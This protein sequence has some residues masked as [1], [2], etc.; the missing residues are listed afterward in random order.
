MALDHASTDEQLSDL[1]CIQGGALPQV[2]RDNP[3]AQ[4]GGN[5]RILS[6]PSTTT[7]PGNFARRSLASWAVIF[8]S[9]SM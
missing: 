4:A 2:V 5:E 8:F 7:M 9:V 3:H 1:D 6:Y